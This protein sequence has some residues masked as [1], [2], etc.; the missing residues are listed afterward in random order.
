MTSK[1]G[2]GDAGPPK[3]VCSWERSNGLYFMGW[4]TV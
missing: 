1:L 4:E 3:S 2:G